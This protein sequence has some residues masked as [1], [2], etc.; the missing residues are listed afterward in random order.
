MSR[1]P[2]I[3][4]CRNSSTIRL[5][6]GQLPRSNNR[7]SLTWP[8]YRPRGH[9]VDQRAYSSTNRFTSVGG[10]T[11]WALAAASFRPWA[12]LGAK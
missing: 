9:E 8:R 11:T 3:V 10:C 2:P 7:R 4:S 6:S 12:S 5:A 1:M